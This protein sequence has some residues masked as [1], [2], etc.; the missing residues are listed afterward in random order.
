MQQ[1]NIHVMCWKYW[2]LSSPPFIIVAEERKEKKEPERPKCKKKNDKP[3]EGTWFCNDLIE[4]VSK[5]DDAKLVLI[6]FHSFNLSS[7]TIFSHGLT[8]SALTQ[9]ANISLTPRY[10]P[11][12]H[13]VCVCSHLD[14][15]VNYPMWTM[16]TL[17]TI[18]RKHTRNTILR[19][20]TSS[21]KLRRHFLFNR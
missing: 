10:L 13:T 14:S 6:Q 11:S 3:E 4:N 12:S 1:K 15:R 2:S 19:R 18:S 8:I 17:S 7:H 21:L 5:Y 16:P 9:L 20:F